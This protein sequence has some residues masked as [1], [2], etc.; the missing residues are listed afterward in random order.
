ML[1][2]PAQH[3]GD[4]RITA[5]HA[6]LDRLTDNPK[7][8]SALQNLSHQGI[9]YEHG[10]LLNSE[11]V[12]LFREEISTP[13]NVGFQVEIEKRPATPP[14][15]NTE[16]FDITMMTDPPFALMPF[17]GPLRE[18]A[19]ATN[20]EVSYNVKISLVYDTVTDNITI[21]VQQAPEVTYRLVGK[22]YEEAGV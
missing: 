15:P 20:T 10:L 18:T 4:D 7:V 14:A 9:A 5:A 2:D 8:Q 13:D 21:Q 6:A 22:E 3:H 1:Y 19:D 17:H 11:F 12:G 16:V